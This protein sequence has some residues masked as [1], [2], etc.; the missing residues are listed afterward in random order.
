MCK[1]DIE[2]LT[3]KEINI[4][5]EEYKDLAFKTT[6]K[7][8]SNYMKSCWKEDILAAAEYGVYIGLR[9]IKLENI[10]NDLSIKTFL[11]FNVRTECKNLIREVHGYEGTANRN[12]YYNT[13]SYNERIGDEGTELELTLSENNLLVNNLLNEDQIIKYMD[14]YNAI[15]K[16]SARD[17]HIVKSLMEN[18]TLSCIAKELGISKDMVFRS[19]HRIFAF[20]KEE[21][22]EIA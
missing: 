17:K 3:G 6:Y 4:L 16:L 1:Y 11:V 22:K 18:K 20:L 14:L 7:Y 21:L 5:F 10:E 19:K 8:F 9:K 2:V 15:D 13:S 12:G